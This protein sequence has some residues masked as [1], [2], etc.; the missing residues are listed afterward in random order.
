M[1]AAFS[2]IMLYVGVVMTDPM[3]ALAFLVSF[4]V[5]VVS[6]SLFYGLWKNR[7]VRKD[8]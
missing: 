6:A 4:F 3:R 8:R 2:V 7:D 1:F 5:A